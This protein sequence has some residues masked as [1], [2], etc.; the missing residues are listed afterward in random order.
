MIGFFR[1][2]IMSSNFRQQLYQPG[3]K[4]DVHNIIFILGRGKSATEPN[5]AS[6]IH[7]ISDSSAMHR[8]W[9]V[10]PWPNWISPPPRRE[11]NRPAR[12]SP[13][14][15]ISLRIIEMGCGGIGRVHYRKLGII[16]CNSG[17]H[18]C[19]E[20]PVTV[21]VT[22]GGGAWRDLWGG[23][24]PRPHRPI[25]RT[26]QLRDGGDEGDCRL[27]WLANSHQF[28]IGKRKVAGTVVKPCPHRDRYRTI[29]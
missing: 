27:W 19:L 10:N 12:K 26:A 11:E 22:G 13:P 5:L 8:E 21:V 29:G 25:M 18:Q 7:Q 20:W 14:P 17:H 15:L 2:V 16:W 28:P 1:C 24:R 6:W 3:K 4:I 23:F 9:T